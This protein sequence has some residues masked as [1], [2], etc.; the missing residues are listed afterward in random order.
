MGEDAIRYIQAGIT[1]DHECF[2]YEEAKHKLLNGMKIAIREGSAARN[3]DALHPLIGEFTDLLMLCSDDKHP[4]ELLLGHIDQLVVRAL[5]LG[6]NLFDVLRIACINPIE[7]YKMNVGMLRPGDPA[8]MIVVKDLVNF[9]NVMTI[10]DGVVW[11]KDGETRMKDKKH[12]APNH[13]NII[14][15]LSKDFEIDAGKSSLP[16]ICALDGQLITEK[17]WT[18]PLVSGGNLI[19]DIGRDL[20]KIVV[21][22]RYADAIPAVA[23]VK[24][25]GLKYGAMASTVAHDSHNIICV[26]VD[27]ESIAGAV[28][29]LV[30]ARGGLSFYSESHKEVLPLPV[31]GL[32]STDSCET[33]G[34]RY[35]HLDQLVKKAGSGL[36]SPYMTL[37]FMALLV[38]PKIKLSDLGLFDAERFEFY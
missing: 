33:V 5:N 18:A 1:T 37:S 2:T 19:A 25:F 36:R 27:D 9:N 35:E 23:F 20:L 32:M 12:E 6:Y 38:I 30:Q 31:A 34:A 3:F 17:E 28:N 11:A 14:E 10:I 21:V 29:M 7:H 13:F 26:G 24:N 22:N 8:D 4:D 15:K 16:V